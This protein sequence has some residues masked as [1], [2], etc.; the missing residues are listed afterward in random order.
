MENPFDKIA[1]DKLAYECA[2]CIEHGVLGSRSGVGDALLLYLNVGGM[3]G[4]VSVPDW[5]DEYEK[6]NNLKEE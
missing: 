5:V 3:R 1:A 2:R 4:P 6:T